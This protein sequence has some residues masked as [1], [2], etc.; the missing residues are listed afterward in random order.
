MRILATSRAPLDIDRE[1]VHRLPPLDTAD[2]GPAVQLFTERARA[3]SPVPIQA[4]DDAVTDICHRLEGI[5]LAIE[6]A[7]ART[8]TLRPV[9]ILTRLDDMLAVLG[10]GR[11]NS[12]ERHRTMAAAIQWSTDAI[13]TRARR[14]L[15]ELSV[16]AGSFTLEAADFVADADDTLDALD[17]LVTNSLISVA[18]TGDHSRFRILEPVRQFA[19]E[20]LADSATLAAAAD[21]HAT[22]YAELAWS[23]SERWRAGDD[24]QAW[25]VARQELAN[26]RRAFDEL[27]SQGRIDDAQRLA[28]AGFGP[29]V[30]QFDYV[31]QYEWGP[32][33]V[34]LDPDHVG[35]WTASACAVATWGAL[36]AGDTD[37]ATELIRRGER[38]L[39]AGSIDDGLL[40]GA[41]MHAV[42]YG[43][44][45]TVDQGFVDRSID[46]ARRSEDR[47][48]AAWVLG[49]ARRAEEAIAAAHE[50]GNQMLMV[51]ARTGLLDGYVDDPRIELED[52][53]H[54][55]Q[56]SHSFIAINS[57]A[58]IFGSFEVTQGVAGDGLLLLR[59]PARSWL[60]H[61]DARVREIL[62]TMAAGLARLG[63]ASSVATIMASIGDRPLGT[64]VG[65]ILH[66]LERQ[67][68][69]AALREVDPTLDPSEHLDLGSAVSFACRR[70]E[71][72]VTAEPITI[73]S[74]RAGLTDRQLA[75]AEL[76]AKGRSQREIADELHI[77]RSDIGRETDELLRRLGARSRTQIA[78]WLIAHPAGT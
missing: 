16:F 26:L 17:E 30:C 45:P 8:R 73:S 76:L 43:A 12:V 33:S 5:P 71:H 50:V 3:V 29:I 49:Y 51:M 14:L 47:F 10:A 67:Y 7:A 23:L 1:W 28:V 68:I 53:W 9:E 38:A 24:Q 32:R 65:P 77:A 39:D 35:P 18:H 72:L 6:L 37:H 48:R 42:T 74:E 70:A 57:T 40:F 11:R 41:A 31:P 55:A 2:G 34:D 63:D 36:S 78:D 60:L 44:G 46:E 56:R 13:S 61:A 66:H 75:V 69:D 25:P 64:H 20:R 58:H 19:V 54:L 4:D 52:A 21:R 22:F 15:A 62:H 59:S 27:C